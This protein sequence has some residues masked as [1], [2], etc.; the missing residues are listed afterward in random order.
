M[1]SHRA[2]FAKVM[3]MR[4]LFAIVLLAACT[5]KTAPERPLPHRMQRPSCLFETQ[6]RPARP[7][8]PLLSLAVCRAADEA[9]TWLPN[10]PLAVEVRTSLV[11]LRGP[12]DWREIQLALDEAGLLLSLCYRRWYRDQDADRLVVTAVV[13]AS[14]RLRAVRSERNDAIGQCISE[15]LST[16]E[17][18]PDGFD[19]ASTDI[20][21]TV[22]FQPSQW[23]QWASR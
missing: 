1:T 14:G 10:D 7:G 3:T 12:R 5:S 4:A 15:V 8:Q 23:T 18:S 19:R 9:R 20:L 2:R 21:A 11:D 6:P 13:Q 22:S 16:V 17:L